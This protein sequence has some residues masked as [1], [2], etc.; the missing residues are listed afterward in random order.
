MVKLSSPSDYTAV[1][2]NYAI[3]QGYYTNEDK[4][5]DLLCE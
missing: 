4:I 3:G 2:P 1:N 5:A